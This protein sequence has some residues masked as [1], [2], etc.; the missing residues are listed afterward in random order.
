MD[1]GGVEA[2]YDSSGRYEIVD[3]SLPRIK[4]QCLPSI[5]IN[6][7]LYIHLIVT[8]L[9]AGFLDQLVQYAREGREEVCA[10]DYYNL[11][12]KKRN[13]NFGEEIVEHANNSARKYRSGLNAFEA[14][15]GNLQ[16]EVRW[17]VA[18]Q[19]SYKPVKPRQV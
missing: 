1:I 19:E 11:S 18:T 14:N 5:D 3:E 2:A 17:Q 10:C 9:S 12:A 4:R 16:V 8:M 7:L 13:Q 6:G 15:L